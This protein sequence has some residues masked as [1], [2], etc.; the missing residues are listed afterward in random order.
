VN[1]NGPPL[2][3]PKAQAATLLSVQVEAGQALRR[4]ITHASSPV[5]LE[6]LRSDFSAWMGQNEDALAR[7]FRETDRDTHRKP[8]AAGPSLP[9]FID[10]R[11][12]LVREADSRLRYLRRAASRAEQAQEPPPATPSASPGVTINNYGFM[13]DTA[14]NPSRVG[15]QDTAGGHRP[16]AGEPP[17]HGPRRKK[18]WWRAVLTGPW[19]IGICTPLIAAALIA[20]KTNALSLFSSRSSVVTGS[21]TCISGRPVVGVW[22]AASSGQ[23]DSGYAHLGPGAASGINHPAG[24]TVTYSYRL[25]HG[26]SY[27]VHVGCG[28]AAKHWASSNYSP[29]LSALAARLRCDDPTATPAVETKPEG[30][31]VVVRGS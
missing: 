8:A 15:P 7:I 27:A 19:T 20:M 5:Q 29:Q 23:G 11:A 21:V 28:G 14:V 24:A 1:D 12:Q 13:V 16:Q 4:K 6:R 30:R 10:Q 25:P 2:K 17:A 18:K 26:G 31:C 22:I 3:I 9:G